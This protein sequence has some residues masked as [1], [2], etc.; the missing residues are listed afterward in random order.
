MRFYFLALV[1][2]TANGCSSPS[3]TVCPPVADYDQPTQSRAATDLKLLPSG[4]PV[5]GMLEDYAV[6]RDQA[7]A[8]RT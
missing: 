5:L 4:S 2:A 1:L 7:R 6:M 3:I 8:C